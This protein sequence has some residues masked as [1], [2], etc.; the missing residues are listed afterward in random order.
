MRRFRFRLAPLLRLRSQLERSARR[1]LAAAL[2]TLDGIEQRLAA[3]TAGVRDCGEQGVRT[4]AVGHLARGL[5]TGLRR[6]MWRLGK[7]RL[8]AQQKVDV[9]RADYAQKAR[10]LKALQ[11]L[12]DQQREVW[13]QD[14]QRAEQAEID[15]LAVLSRG[16]AAAQLGG[17]EA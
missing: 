15:E 1:E 9:A 7:Q 14:V 2:G 4:D 11:R 10:D 16:A 13:R 8:E 6:L 12:R 5:E 17:E 3:A